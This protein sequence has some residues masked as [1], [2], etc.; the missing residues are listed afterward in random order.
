MKTVGEFCNIK[1]SQLA[2]SLADLIIN[3]F[4][5]PCRTADSDHIFGNI[6]SYDRTCAY[7][8]IVTDSHSR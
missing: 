6:L 3:A 4:Y 2:G 7:D 1:S 5:H 8:R